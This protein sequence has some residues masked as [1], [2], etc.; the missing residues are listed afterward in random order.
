MRIWWTIVGLGLLST[1][2]FQGSSLATS[3]VTQVQSCDGTSA[4]LVILASGTTP[5]RGRPE[6]GQPKMKQGGS[7]PIRQGKPG[8]DSCPCE[9]R[10]DAKTKKCWFAVPANCSSCVQQGTCAY[11]N[12]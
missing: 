6:Q 8:G 5:E 9:C 12:C 10:F 3:D 4:G 2:A 1:L 11:P 7:P